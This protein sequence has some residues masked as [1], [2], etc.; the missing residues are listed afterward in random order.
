MGLTFR[1]E[2]GAP[3]THE[4]LDENFRSFFY[5]ASFAEN[6]LILQRKDGT[7]ATVPIGG[8]AFADFQENGGS[9]GDVYIADSQITG[10]RMIIDLFNGQFYDKTKAMNSDGGNLSSDEWYIDFDP[11]ASAPYYVHFGSNFAISS[12]G[13]LYA[14]G[15][16]IEGDITASSGL[17]GGFSITPDTIHGPTT[18]GVPTFFISGAAGPTDHFISASNFS[19]KGNGDITGSSV[20]F[21]GGTIAGWEITNTQIKKSTNIVL[22]AANE[23]I[24]INDST[25]GNRGIQ[26][27]YNSGTPRFYVGDATGSFVKFDGTNVSLSTSLLEISASNIEIS[28]TEA[29]MSLGGG[30]IKLLGATSAIEVGVSNKFRISGSAT[31]AMIVAGTKTGFDTDDAGIIIGMNSTVP[32][33]DLTKDANNYVRFNPTSGVDIK[34]DTFKLDTTYFDIDTATQRLNIFDTA[35]AE[36]IR[37]GEISDAADDLYG[38][39]IFNGSGTGSANTIAMFGQQGN[40]IGGWEITDSQ[41]R[42]IPTAGFGGTYGENETGLVIHSDGKLESSNFVSNLKGWRI[43]TIGNGSA[44]FENM[45]IRGTLSTTVF[46]KETVNVVGGQLMV[47]NATTIQP[48]KDTDGVILAGSSSY[49][50]NAVTFSVANTSGF[51]E[52]E[53]LKIKSVNDAGF[54][55]EYVYISGSKRYSED[56]SITGNTGSID[57]DGLAG[58]LYVERSYGGTPAV[59]SSVTTLSA[60]IATTGETTINVA[61]STGLGVQNIIKIGSE[62]LKVTAIN[63]TVLTVIRDYHDTA[64]NSHVL[65]D[66]VFLVDLDAEF[67]SGL[68]S[69]AKPYNEGQVLVS[70]GVFNPAQDISSGY[71]M[72]N[73][74]PRDVSTPYMDIVERTGSGAY[75]L[76]LR[77]RLGDLSGL[78]SGYLYG[79]NEPGFGLY[80]E[81][82]FFRG[83]ITAQTGSIAGQLHVATVAGGLE[84][85]QKVTIGL[86]VSGNNDG[87]YINNNNYWYTDGGWKVG[88]SDNFISLDN[89][90]DGNLVI[91]TETFALDTS[92]FIISS[93]LNNGTLAAGTNASSMTSTAGTGV[94][95]DGN[96]KFRVGTGTTGANYIYWDGTTLNIKGNID[97]TG[98]TGAT[99]ADLDAITGSLSSSL[100]GEISSSDAAFSASVES[101]TDTLDGKIFTDSAGRA[102]RPPTASAEGLYLAS[103]NLGFY[104]DGEWKTYM[105]NQGDFFLTGSA[106][107][108]LAW[109]SATGALTI[110]GEINITSGNAATQDYASSSAATAESA[111]LAALSEVSASLSGS[112]SSSTATLQDGLDSANLLVS[113]KAA[114]FRQNDAPS[115][116]SRTVGDMWIDSNDG[117]K[118][119]VW[120]GT[121]WAV[122]PDGTYDQAVL[123]NTTSASLSSSV[124]ADIFTDETGRLV[125]TPS[126]SSAGLYLGDTALG[127]YSASEWRTYMSNNGN[128]YL[129]GSDGNYL[130]WDGGQLSI[131]GSINITG[132]NAATSDSVNDAQ[133]AAEAF[134]S[135]SAENAVLSGSAAATAAQTAAEATAAAALGSATSSLET[136][137][138]QSNVNTSASFATQ[139]QTNTAF[140]LV[141]AGLNSIFRQNEAPTTESRHQG[142]MWIDQNDGERLYIFSGSSWIT[143]SDSTYDQSSLIT[144]S[145]ATASLDTFT[146]STG[147]IVSTPSPNTAGLYLGD[148]ALGFYS[149]SEW[150]TFMANNGNFFLTG[151]DTNYLKWN[152]TALTISGDINILGGNAATQD[153]ASS[154]AASAESASL[155]ATEAVET[156]ASASNAITNQTAVDAS[157]TA[158]AALQTAET[159]ASRSV[160][161]SGK[162]T[163]NP[164]PSGQGLFFNANNL[165]YYSGSKWNAYLS[166]SGEFYL[167]G[168]GNGGMSWD[169]EDLS[170]DGTVVARAGEIGGITL[171]DSKLYNGEGTHSDADT[172]F[173]LDSSSN[174]SLGDKLVWNASTQA[175]TISGEINVTNPN[176]FASQ[177][178]LE[179]EQSSSSDLFLAAFASASAAQEAATSASLEA[180]ASSS[181]AQAAAE[182]SAAA[183]LGTATG[184]LE[185][186]IGNVATTASLSASAAQ[187]AAE[188]AATSALNTATGSLQTYA[189][190]AVTNIT[191]SI[192]TAQGTANAATASAAAA[193]LE[194]ATSSSAAQAAAIASAAT[195]L[196][197]ATGSLQTA[198]GNVATTASLSAS[199]AQTAAEATAAAALNTATGSL[200]TYANSAVTAITGSI[201]TAQGTAN[202]ATGS[203]SAAQA[204][205]NAATASAA[206]AKQ[207]A[208]AATGSINEIV[209]ATSSMVNP[210]TYS[211]GPDAAHTLASLP[212]PPSTA[213]LYQSFDGFGFHDGT[214]FMTY[215]SSSGDFIL[216]GSGDDGLIW[217][218]TSLTIGKAGKGPTFEYLFS[219]SLDTNVFDVSSNI[220][221]T[222]L[223]SPFGNNFQNSGSAGWNKGFHSK[224]LFDREDEGIF[225]WDVIVTNFYPA[226]AIGLFKESPAT[227][228]KTQQLHSVYFHS[229]SGNGNQI[230]VE[231][232]GTYKATIKMDAWVSQTPTLFRVSI[233]LKPTGAIYKV[234]KNGDF[235]APYATY[236]SQ[237]SGLTDRYVRPG[238]SIYNT[239]SYLTFYKMSAGK[240]IGTSTKISGNAVQTG[241][242]QS[243][244]WGTVAGSQLDLDAGTFRLGGSAV[245]KLE[246]DG[247]SLDVIGNIQVTNPD[248]FATPSTKNKSDYN[249]ILV[250][251]GSASTITSPYTLA[252]VSESLGFT[253][254][255]G[256][257]WYYD[258]NGVANANTNPSNILNFD[259][260]DY[261]LYVFDERNW[262]LTTS[263]I[264]LALELFDLGKSVLITGNDTNVGNYTGSYNTEWPIKTAPG[265]SGTGWMVGGSASGQGLPASHPIL[266]GISTT[267]NVSLSTSG[268]SGNY[269]THLKKAPGGGTIVHPFTLKGSATSVSLDSN[270]VYV[271][272]GIGEGI[273]SFIATNPRGGRLVNLNLYGLNE[274]YLIPSASKN[275]VNFLL[276]TDPAIEAH[277]MQVTSITGEMVTTG[278]IESSN[279]N[280]TSGTYSSDGT[281]FN[282]DSGNLISKEFSIVSGNA[283]FKGDIS[284][285]TGNSIF[286]ATSAGIQLGHATFASAP[287]SVTPTGNIKATSGTVGVL[288][289]A[290]NEIYFGNGGS[291]DDPDTPFYLNDNGEFS[292]GENFVYDGQNEELLIKGNSTFSGTVTIGS[293]PLTT[294]NT[295]NTEDPMTGAS[296]SFNPNFLQVA[297]D[298]RPAGVFASYGSSAASTIGYYP[299]AAA[300]ANGEIRIGSSDSSTGAS[301]SAFSVDPGK[302]YKVTIR[303]RMSAN[304]TSGIYFR[305]AEKD[306]ELDAGTFAITSNTVG[307]TGVDAKTTNRLIRHSTAPNGRL[308]NMTSNG[309]TLTSMEDMGMSTAYSVFQFIYEPT[310]NQTELITNGD[311]TG[312]TTGWNIR[313][314]DSVTHGVLN[315]NGQGARTSTSFTPVVGRTYIV[316]FEIIS[317]TSGGISPYTGSGGV[318]LAGTLLTSPGV[319]TYTYTQGNTT[320][321]NFNLYAP[322]SFIGSISNI[323]LKEA[324][325]SLAKYASVQVLNWGGAGTN[326]LI[327]DKVVVQETVGTDIY[328]GTVAGWTVNDT[329]IFSGNAPDTDGYADAGGLTLSSGGSIHAKQ[330]YIDNQGNAN[331]KGSI[332]GASGDFAGNLNG[333]TITG[334]NI[335]IGSTYITD[336][337]Y[338][339][340][341][342]GGISLGGTS[343]TDTNA[344][345]RVNTQGS[346][347]ATSGQIGNWQIAGSNLLRDSSNQIFLDPN[348]KSIK[349]NDTS[350]NTKIEI[351]ANTLPS[352]AP[353]RVADLSHSGVTRTLHFWRDTSSNSSNAYWGGAFGTTISSAQQ[354]RTTTKTYTETASSQYTHAG[355][356]LPITIPIAE[357]DYIGHLTAQ[358]P[359]RIGTGTT[360]T[361]LTQNPSTYTFSSNS[362]QYDLFNSVTAS[363]VH[364]LRVITELEETGGS[365]ANPAWI[366]KNTT[367]YIL[368]ESTIDSD[369][370]ARM[371]KGSLAL[372]SGT[373][374]SYASSF[375]RQMWSDNR[376][377]VGSGWRSQTKT[378]NLGT[379]P[380]GNYRVRLRHSTTVTLSYKF[381]GTVNTGVNTGTGGG[382]AEVFLAPFTSTFTPITFGTFTSQVKAGLNGVQISGPD[383]S[384]LLGAVADD[385]VANIYGNALVTGELTANVTGLSDRRLKENI[386]EIEDPLALIGNLNPKA[387][388][389]KMNANPDEN[390]RN[391]FGFIAQEVSGS[392][393]ELI[394]K[395]S[396]I[397]HL[398]EVLSVEQTPFIAL[399]TA[400]IQSLINKLAVLEERIEELETPV[401]GSE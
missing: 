200:Q 205:A 79:N 21:S 88:G 42:T 334:G 333:A 297:A 133:A 181:A 27:E 23:S 112:I 123:I 84:T 325:T 241:A 377:S 304:V 196:G 41:I 369:Y 264:Q 313:S 83:A 5:T 68:V 71:I 50:A 48:L 371:P 82:G 318:N 393:P 276:R 306:S 39:K 119:Y 36:I 75:D 353:T 73:A 54:S 154:S 245:P 11:A 105:D 25:F 305:V 104:K 138:S 213:G 265:T 97:I 338:F 19:L 312:G 230:R 357:F 348:N 288:T 127:F 174:F 166:A 134:A 299:N 155:A 380:S 361:S 291:H 355:G 159:A 102:V 130:A 2:K 131:K 298:G 350:G 376:F 124:A 250:S 368:S 237:V 167:T 53:I 74:N 243:S 224:D 142:D 284:I 321:N 222:A 33:L 178:E 58:E 32:T 394:S 85:G 307:E 362:T 252:Y 336:P 28:S 341:D 342:A 14:S 214:K 52:G 141:Q 158:A 160:D 319:Y 118:V 358:M 301:F 98:G 182:A 20:M 31:D 153:Y 383:G 61:D 332:T 314:G 320:T 354:S 317:Y 266:A 164:T 183:A 235:T 114:I 228:D 272:N 372:V 57:P 95:L 373:T 370:A 139:A 169:G 227:F 316:S 382:S 223:G 400:G 363:Y 399:N 207:L 192:L 261:D 346:L 17:I 170:I 12:S 221:T 172:G 69:T 324:N 248:T 16:V 56:A 254:G 256:T 267:G 129:T 351:S 337:R 308:R 81:N 253:G 96:G 310:N 262:G 80:T 126:T 280:Y 309:N 387:F 239:T 219:G 198:I 94:Y 195:S 315:L 329:A 128:F 392:F 115:T 268:D 201:L 263:E 244:N 185:T 70:T 347:S 293:T 303:A 296:L 59:S 366:T 51:T 46:E 176:D 193:S 388:R 286:K 258:D 240:T 215:M 65:G 249:I 47:S 90:T 352:I 151:S 106:G 93:S 101:T 136:S 389:W 292:I 171:E 145:I 202:A 386:K 322:T 173:Y 289:I 217:N 107:N 191:G 234:Y 323:T 125:G 8:E 344:E 281:Q 311:F 161:A 270:D 35:S 152:G 231:E 64:A 66:T 203:A 13:Y 204:T 146:D 189:D 251:T 186:T 3:L 238:A 92:T 269:I 339:R 295:L 120:S 216:S 26:L 395:Q 279:Y 206:I 246:W 375:T 86:D 260:K 247:A 67:L 149:A 340:A 194:A 349:I 278:K 391:S 109:D 274:N 117:N 132:G 60:D 187:T 287:F 367:N 72:M 29:S 379:Q 44:E 218:G 331:F 55:V 122:T 233:Q 283:N 34:T 147:R 396:K 209:A 384:V 45:R 87:I 378:I 91:N 365:N 381:N 242:I 18:L 210:L 208:D 143:A 190:G 77:S 140:N 49:A 226:T 22:D 62:R 401:T 364:T 116:T 236:D 168:S 330:F 275:L 177:A 89:F 184:S 111:S 374:T 30:S 7:T 10:S 43:D 232:N 157:S 6:Q 343:T 257:S 397:G 271:A 148:E 110:A 360:L 78:A 63:S 150:R 212:T 108:K 385:G 356:S 326:S 302:K 285:G 359:D 345:F 282:L 37:L 188:A 290:S 180:A 211:F 328:T 103:T 144:D 76:Q 121:D 175:L 335:V 15:A 294:A 100:A 327:I 135:A 40:K 229:F 137:I 220:I 4:E 165:G 197:T 156:A 24:S 390:R 300:S 255:N 259:S 162:I 277:Y 225:E 179:A 398:E 9:I 273:S 113:G 99:S 163:F 1:D 38:I 199:A